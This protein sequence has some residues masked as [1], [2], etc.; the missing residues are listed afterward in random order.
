MSVFRIVGL[1]VRL[2]IAV[3]IIGGALMLLLF[4]L[5]GLAS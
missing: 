3:A 5:A 2:Y 1:I 4:A